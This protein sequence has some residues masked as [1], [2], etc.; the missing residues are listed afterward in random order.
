MP[1]LTIIANKV[2]E[3]MFNKFGI[4]VCVAIAVAS[5]AHGGQS[6]CP[7]VSEVLSALPKSDQA[8]SVQK[9]GEELGAAVS[10][11]EPLHPLANRLKAEMPGVQDAM[12]VDV[13]VA[14]Y[15]QN[16]TSTGQ[17]GS[18]QETLLTHFETLAN[19]AVF[20]A[21]SDDVKQGGWLYD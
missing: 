18:E 1:V 10:A 20:S 16:L 5:V 17:S 2:E 19:D 15:C 9:I 14:A 3:E 21:P 6:Q 13:M 7:D 8:L 11:N 12:I 4:A